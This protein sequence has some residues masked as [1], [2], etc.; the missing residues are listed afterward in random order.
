[1]LGYHLSVGWRSL[2]L[3]QYWRGVDDL[4]GYAGDAGKHHRPAWLEHF[5]NAFKTG[6]VGFWHETYVVSPG[7][8]EQIY[9][10]MP[11]HGLAAATKAVEVGKSKNTARQRLT[12]AA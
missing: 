3:V 1:M 5:R 2:T 9:L 6:A 8:H 12:K 11:A 4:V 10:N 7:T